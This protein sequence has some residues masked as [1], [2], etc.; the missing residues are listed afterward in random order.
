ML[1]S[2]N[3]QV[4]FPPFTVLSRLNNNQ[5]NYLS[6]RIDK[7]CFEKI[8]KSSFFNC[9][10]ED[11]Q[12]MTL[13][14]RGCLAIKCYL[15]N[16]STHIVTD[17]F[18][19]LV[20]IKDRNYAIELMGE[21]TCNKVLT[22]KELFNSSLYD[23]IKSNYNNFGIKIVPTF[24]N[25]EKQP[26]KL[27]SSLSKKELFSSW[28]SRCTIVDFIC[29]FSEPEDKKWIEYLHAYISLNETI[30][31]SVDQLI[32]DALNPINY[33]DQPEDLEGS[34]YGISTLLLDKQIDSLFSKEELE[35][36]IFGEEN[37]LLKNNKCL[38]KE[39]ESLR[40][41]L[42]LYNNEKKRSENRL[43][44][45]NNL[46]DALKHQF[47][48][49]KIDFL[50]G[51]LSNEELPLVTLRELILGLKKIGEIDCI[52]LIA[53]KISQQEFECFPDP[54]QMQSISEVQESVQKKAQEG[55]INWNIGTHFTKHFSED[56][57]GFLRKFQIDPEVFILAAK[58]HAVSIDSKCSDPIEE[59]ISRR[60][61]T[62]D[63]LYEITLSAI[64]I[65]LKKDLN[66]IVTL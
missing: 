1:S 47:P 29:A 48:N 45:L 44:K 53:E 52:N 46:I 39:V 9:S 2:I 57:K 18:N 7:E 59:V 8:L 66:K 64:K 30:K 12:S 36:I 43:A 56:I 65:Q 54:I 23:L 37:S 17:L 62:F 40:K 34:I 58:M 11:I 10:K 15:L 22:D 6:N 49:L 61:F 41:P 38:Q 16:D 20:S 28:L 25:Q 4:K 42:D 60:E 35:V 13:S 3:S 31:K 21:I 33:I 14:S 27:K 24:K 32:E 63:Q 5:L 50:S 55:V 26:T 19:A 51:N